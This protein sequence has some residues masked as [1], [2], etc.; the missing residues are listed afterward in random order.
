MTTNQGKIENLRT[1]IQMYNLKSL[2][3]NADVKYTKLRRFVMGECDIWYE[4]YLKIRD[5]I[6]TRHNNFIDI[7]TA[8]K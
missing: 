7:D 2:S 1:H 5:L 6:V 8:T 3:E 4:D